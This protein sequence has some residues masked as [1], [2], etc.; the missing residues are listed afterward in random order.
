MRHV[1]FIEVGMENYGPYLD[2]MTLAFNDDSLVLIT[3]P[4]GIGKTMALDAIPFTLYGITSKGM[5]GDDVV[6]NVAGKNCKTWVKFAIDNDNYKVTRYQA[7][8]KLGNTVVLN[9]NGVDIKKGQKEVLPE[10]E[11]LVCSKKSF[12]NTLMFGQKVKDFFTDLVDSDKKQI[13]RELLALEQYQAYYNEANNRLKAAKEKLEALQIEKGIQRGLLD[14]TNEQIAIFIEAE[15]QFEID[16]AK[17]IN[18][19][20]KAN[21]TDSRLLNEWQSKLDELNKKNVDIEKTKEEISSLQN[22]LKTIAASVDSQL[23]EIESQKQNKALEVRNKASEATTKVT[24]KYRDKIDVVVKEREKIKDELHEFVTQC[25]S[26]KHMVENKIIENEIKIQTLQEKAIEMKNSIVF[27]GGAECPTC[28]QLISDDTYQLFEEKTAEYE[29]QASELQKE[30]DSLKILMKQ[31]SKEMSDKA[32]ILNEKRDLL[33]NKIQTYDNEKMLEVAKLEERLGN[34]IYQINEVARTETEKKKQ[35]IEDKVNEIKASLNSL[36][37]LKIKQE[38]IISSINTTS[39][40]I[41]NLDNDIAL[42]ENKIKSTEETEYDKTQLNSYKA[43][44]VVI[45]RKLFEINES[46][47]QISRK[48]EIYDF[49]KTAFSSSGIPSMLIDEA[50]P[51]MNEKVSYY[52]DKFTNGRYIVSFDTLAATKA[53]EFRDKISVNVID[54]YTRANSRVQLSGGQTRIVDI[55]TILTLADLQE[56]IQDVSIN[57]MLFDEIFDSLDDENIGYVSRVLSKLKLGKSIYLISH[58]H[59]DQLEADE[60]LKFA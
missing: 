47:N 1:N 53:G 48:C 21:E 5:K 36:N 52:L 56:N 39:Q 55:A 26:K 37:E 25:Q 46:G 57:I 12:M 15:K 42:R 6:N 28:H 17:N 33:A 2:P 8:S 20:K 7:Y 38:E 58:R 13:F 51:F 44:L 4:N 35:E 19:L 9:K 27:A 18:E 40:T 31:I 49:W 24:K 59:E 11:R 43:K 32:G 16:K 54:T 45:E 30:V 23:R 3:G 34:V 10:I 22:E 29:S 14:D 41:T 50:I 60:I